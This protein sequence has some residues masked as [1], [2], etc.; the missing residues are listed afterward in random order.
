M[1]SID[2]ALPHWVIQKYLLLLGHRA[3]LRVWGPEQLNILNIG[4]LDLNFVHDS[5][6]TATVN[7]TNRV[8]YTSDGERVANDGKIKLR[9]MQ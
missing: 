9:T 3:G 6:D 7:D 8:N 5:Y 1:W 4:T 2:A